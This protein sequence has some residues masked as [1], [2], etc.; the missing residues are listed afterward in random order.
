M[1][2]V[3]LIKL[4]LILCVC[5]SSIDLRQSTCPSSPSRASAT[6]KQYTTPS[7]TSSLPIPSSPD[8]RFLPYRSDTN[9]FHSSPTAQYNPSQPHADTAKRTAHPPPRTP[10]TLPDTRHTS[11][12]LRAESRSRAEAAR[13]AGLLPQRRWVRASK[14]LLLLLFL[15]AISFSQPE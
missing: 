12:R 11:S 1:H 13:G 9:Y 3:V 2:N 6:N 4:I 8:Q 15:F 10:R 5:T 7:F 14:A